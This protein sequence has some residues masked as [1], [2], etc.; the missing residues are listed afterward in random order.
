VK[1]ACG[2]EQMPPESEKAATVGA[3][4]LVIEAGR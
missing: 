1:V 3:D 4:G 2:P